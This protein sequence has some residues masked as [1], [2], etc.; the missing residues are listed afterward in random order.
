M[1][2]RVGLD[3]LDLLKC[4]KRDTR[5]I[6]KLLMFVCR[7]VKWHNYSTEYE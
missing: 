1:A 7:Y 2:E 4:D 6:C 3:Y 5:H